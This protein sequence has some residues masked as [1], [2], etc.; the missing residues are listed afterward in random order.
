MGSGDAAPEPLHFL[1][2]LPARCSSDRADRRTNESKRRRYHLT[3]DGN[4]MPPTDEELFI[5]IVKADKIGFDKG[6]DP[7]ARSL[8]TVER[9]MDH[10]GHRK[11]ISGGANVHPLVPRIQNIINEL[12]RPNDIGI[13]AVQLGAFMFRDVFAR[14]I[15]PIIFGRPQID[16]LQLIDLN[17]MQKRM[18]SADPMQLQSYCDQFADLYDFAYGRDD[19]D[20]MGWTNLECRNFMGLAHFQ[21]QASAAIITGAFDFRGAVQSALVGTE[22]ILKAGLLASGVDK[23]RLRILGHDLQSL[24]NELVHHKTSFDLHR[25]QHSIS[26]FPQY[27]PNRY[28]AQQPTRREIGHIIMSAQYI[29]S[30]VVRQFSSRNFRIDSG[31]TSKRVYPPDPP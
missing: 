10:L 22:L 12:Y 18:L 21:L 14:V 20:K 7:K 2:R 19:I 28:S 11:Y 15:V 1:G 3:T 31:M 9:V 5:L 23:K 24:A 30:E 27:V 17:S 25:V 4:D 29:A 13:G 26:R 16:L 8:R 6:E